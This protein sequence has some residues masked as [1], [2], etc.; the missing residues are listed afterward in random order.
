MMISF[1]EIIKPCVREISK[2]FQKDF[3]SVIAVPFML[4]HIY[5]KCWIKKEYFLIKMKHFRRTVYLLVKQTTKRTLTNVK[6]L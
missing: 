5:G 4:T 3:S 2:C 1:N 6:N